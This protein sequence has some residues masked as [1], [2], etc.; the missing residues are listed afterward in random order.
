MCCILKQ[1]L[2]GKTG[3]DFRMDFIQ[4]EGRGGGEW[5]REWQM[6]LP[7]TLAAGRYLR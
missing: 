3:T 7:L 4:W 1:V 5:G 2:V 6:Y